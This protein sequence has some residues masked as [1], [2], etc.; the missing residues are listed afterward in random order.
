LQGQALASAAYQLALRYAHERIQGVEIS[1]MK[2]VDAPR[3]PIIKHPDV[4]RMLIYQKAYVEGLRALLYKAAYFGDLAKINKVAGNEE[5]AEKYQ[6]LI[7]LLTPICKA[8]ASDY[9]FRCIELAMQVYGGYGYCR[10]YGIEQYLRDVKIS[11]IYEGTNGI[12]ALDLLGRKIAIKGGLL[13]MRYMTELNNFVDAHNEHPALAKQIAVLAKARDTLAEITMSFGQMSASGNM[14][15]PVLCASP[16]LDLFGHIVVAHLL[17]EE[18]VV[19]HRKLEELFAAKG[20][21]TDDAKRNLIKEH[22]DARFYAGK[23][24]SAKFFTHYVLPHAFAIAETIKSNDT[25]AL[26]IEFESF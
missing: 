8:Y 19:A 26:D 20:A 15:Y 14:I 9:A 18:A 1:Q 2:N 6:D 10:E 16:Y 25:S 3:V 12:Q 5:E 11:S 17:L 13:F 22:S 7:D 24:E 21:S 4:R 23:I